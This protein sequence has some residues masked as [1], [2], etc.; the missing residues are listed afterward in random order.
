LIEAEI[1][2][3]GGDGQIGR[4][5]SR[6]APPGWRVAAPSEGE[7]DIGDPAKVGSQV[8]SRPWSAV[9]NC[10]AYTAVDRAE[11]EIATAWRVNALG[12]AALAEATAR[13][14]IPLIQLSTDYVF[15]GRKA[16]AYV[17]DDPVAPLSVYGASKEGGEQAV[18][19]G[20][21]RHLILRTAWIVS[22]HG[23]NFVKTM[24]RLA[25]ERPVLRVVDDQIGSPTSASDVAA[26]LIAIIE[27]QLSG[28]PVNGTYHFVNDGE[29]SWYDFAVAIFTRLA[30]RGGSAP[31]L[32][33]IPTSQY[34]TPAR[35]PAHSRLSTAK[36]V[37]DLAIVPRPW[38]IAAG[39]VIDTILDQATARASQ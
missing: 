8:A 26:A 7:W 34:P 12:P 37:R 33:A 3:T 2:L 11:T 1:L 22:P 16:D 4:E 5:F 31:A 38:R 23:V 35:R 18:R 28:Q 29:A 9:V 21:P 19:T 39:E 30:E 25:K 20:N 15:D 13:A 17:E 6:L 36:L 14:D 24:L 27:R 10:A 32:E